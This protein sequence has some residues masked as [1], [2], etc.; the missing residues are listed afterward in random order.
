VRSHFDPAGGSTYWIERARGLGIDPLRDLRRLDDLDLLGVMEAGDL[1]DRSIWDFV[2][3]RLQA[4][5]ARLTLAETGGTTG[6]PARTA[7]DALD[8]RRAFV[9]PF[10]AVAGRLGFPRG[11]RWAY[12]GPSGP[13]V[14]GKAARAVC[15]RMGSPD[16][17]AVDFDP[18][19]Y[20]AQP[21]GSLLRRSYMEHVLDQAL[22]ILDR[23][24]VEVL[25]GTPP[26]LAALAA[27]LP[28]PRRLH[29]S[30]LHLGGLP[31]AAGDARA[32]RDGFPRAVFLSGYGN[33]LLGMCPQLDPGLEAPV[34]YPHGERLR[35][36]LVRP[37][38]AREAV[39]DIVECGERGRVIAS[40]LDES[41]LIVNL[42][43]RDTA[44]RWPRHPDG[45]SLGFHHE[46]LGD[47]RPLEEVPRDRL[48]IY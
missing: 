6:R 33:T 46:G 47:P 14:I 21:P 48:G 16:P 27:R 22:D 40:R 2:P 17:F 45:P 39:L 42:L 28:A 41:F 15:R 19:W 12:L 25:F 26:V 20:R 3:A 31:A 8:F 34:Y 18:R 44:V 37:G 35:I 29:V 30:A 36:R 38:A 24:P 4:R 32:L 5:L 43:E 7:F 13:H 1:R 11:K 9:D 23:E 10:L